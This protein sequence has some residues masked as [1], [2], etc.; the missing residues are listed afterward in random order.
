MK[1]MI[2]NYFFQFNF[3][4]KSFF[5]KFIKIKLQILNLV[6]TVIF[7]KFLKN[8]IVIDS[9]LCNVSKI[10]NYSSKYSVK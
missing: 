3:F 5:D 2:F 1:K 7:V 10:S 4:K 6:K 8:D 9:M